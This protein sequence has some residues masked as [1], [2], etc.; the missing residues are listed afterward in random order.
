MPHTPVER[1]ALT[2]ATADKWLADVP[3]GWGKGDCIRLAAD[4]VKRFGHKVSL[5]RGG[6]YTSALGARRALK[7][8]GGDDLQALLDSV[9]S[10][11]RL[12][13]PAFAMIGDLVT[14]PG[15]ESF[16]ALVVYLGNGSFLGWHE[17]SPVCCVINNVT[18]MKAA[19]RV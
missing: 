8:A 19:W 1:A 4:H 3:F 16:D 13:A 12:P 17:V 9:P 5:S 2:Q 6:S 10:L 18:E 11:L 15:S 7:R 14:L